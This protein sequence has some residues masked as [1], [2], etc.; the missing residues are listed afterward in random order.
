MASSKAPEILAYLADAALAAYKIVK[1]GTDQEHAAVCSA[2]TDK[3][4]GITQCA[5]T[6]AEDLLEVAVMGGAK[7]KIGGTVSVGDL[8]TSDSS[9]LAVAT[10]S[11]NDRVIGIAMESGVVNDVI[12][13][14]VQLS[15]V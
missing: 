6:A 3:A 9:G 10:T 1:V 4:I 15:N 2:G 14:Q 12:G 8:L 13:C 5:S 11:A 7:V